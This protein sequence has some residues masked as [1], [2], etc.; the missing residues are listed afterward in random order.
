MQYCLSEKPRVLPFA[1]EKTCLQTYPITEYQPIYFLT[2]SFEEA[3]QKLKYASVLSYSLIFW[4]H[5]HNAGA[6][7]TKLL[8]ANMT[9][10][11]PQSADA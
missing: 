2:E 10:E 6:V 8:Q 3:K 4:T 1:P 11:R 9:F 7:D 5:N